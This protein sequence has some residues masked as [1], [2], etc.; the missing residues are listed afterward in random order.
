MKAAEQQPASSSTAGHSAE[1]VGH[2]LAFNEHR[3]NIDAVYFA[4]RGNGEVEEIKTVDMIEL[5]RDVFDPNMRQMALAV[6]SPDMPEA[7]QLGED[8]LVSECEATN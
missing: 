3:R 7:Q 2:I 4:L 8:T 6:F 5:T 1:L